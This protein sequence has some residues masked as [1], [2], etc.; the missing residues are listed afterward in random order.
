[1]SKILILEGELILTYTWN[2]N[3]HNICGHIFEVIDYFY[4]LKDFFDTRILFIGLT[5]TDFK[6][7]LLKYNFTSEEIKLILSCT[8][9]HETHPSI[10]KCENILFTDG[11]ITTMKYTT[12]LSK[13]V[14]AFVC[15][16]K[17]IRYNND[18]KFYILQDNRIY[19]PVQINGINYKKKILFDKLKKP[20]IKNNTLMYCTGNCRLYDIEEIKKYIETHNENIILLTDNDYYDSLSNICNVIRTPYDK[21]MEINKY[22]YTPISRKWDC[23]PRLIAE[24]FYFGIEVEYLNID[25]YNEDL[26]LYYRKL[27]IETNFDSLY[28]TDNDEIVNILKNIFK[29]KNDKFK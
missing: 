25:Y 10:I 2:K 4:I 21:F 9:F 22:V 27:D 15:G 3:G 17:E 23:S 8:I 6:T 7:T 13:S 29:G 14:I 5:E 16:N 20:N 28:L 26:G 1:M 18:P 12:F 24:C 19:D 11:D